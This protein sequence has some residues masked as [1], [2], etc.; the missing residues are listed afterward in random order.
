M[1]RQYHGADDGGG[2]Q[3]GHAP[4]VAHQR[5]GDGYPMVYG[6]RIEC[7]RVQH[8]VKGFDHGRHRGRES[9]RDHQRHVLQHRDYH[10]QLQHYGHCLAVRGQHHRSE[11]RPNRRIDYAPVVAHQRAGNGVNL[12]ME[13]GQW[14]ERV[15][16]V[17]LDHSNRSYAR[18][19]ERVHNRDLHQQ[20]HSHR[21][22]FDHG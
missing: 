5:N 9:E 21:Q 3:S 8:V 6:D 13:R 4:M 7:E 14:I 17:V 15:Q 18:Q 16:H 1:R 12:R 2:W 20:R 10:G 19:P 11:Q 22:P